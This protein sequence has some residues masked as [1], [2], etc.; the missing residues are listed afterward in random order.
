M[1]LLRPRKVRPPPS[2]A[3]PQSMAKRAVRTKLR[4]A[5]LGCLRIASERILLLRMES[6][7]GHDARSHHGAPKEKS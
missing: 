5:N 3:R 4:F 1:P 7:R 2:P 6:H